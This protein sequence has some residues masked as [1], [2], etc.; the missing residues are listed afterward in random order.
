MEQ[1]EVVGTHHEA[2]GA[3][4]DQQHSCQRNCTLN[5]HGI[6]YFSMQILF[7]R[8]TR[9]R[10]TR[11]DKVHPAWTRRV[12]PILGRDDQLPRQRWRADNPSNKN[13]IKN[14]W[15]SSIRAA[16]CEI[17]LPACKINQFEFIMGV[18]DY[19]Q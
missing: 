16:W 18:P 15:A 17:H 12:D 6:Y 7:G 10:K 19:R 2:R 8:R 13:K 1:N 5:S 14:I 4:A 3:Q 11:R 9:L